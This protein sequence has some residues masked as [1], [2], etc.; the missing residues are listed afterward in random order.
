MRIASDWASIRTRGALLW[1]AARL[2]LVAALW[3]GG[4]W[5]GLFATE[6]IEDAYENACIA[7]E[8]RAID[9]PLQLLRYSVIAN[10]FAAAILFLRDAGRRSK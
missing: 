9:W 10:A 7:T 5:L 8:C 6:V 4:L 2:W 3:L 1:Q